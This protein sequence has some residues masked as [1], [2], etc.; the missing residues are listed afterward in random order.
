VICEQFNAL[1]TK[2]LD[3][4]TDQ[5]ILALASHARDC[6]ACEAALD[7]A[8]AALDDPVLTAA[9]QEIADRVVNKFLAELN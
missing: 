1:R 3:E 4:L 6:L 2:V 7:A 5:Q 8:A 9:E